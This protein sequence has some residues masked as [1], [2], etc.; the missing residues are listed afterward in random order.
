MST[1]QLSIKAPPALAI[2]PGDIIPDPGQAGPIVWSTMVNEYLLWNGT[3]WKRLLNPVGAYPGYHEIDH[4][5]NSFAQ[6]DG[7]VNLG[8][9]FTPAA[10]GVCYG[11]R[12]Y[13]HQSNTGVHR[14]GIWKN[15]AVKATGT[16]VN[17]TAYGWQYLYFDEPVE[18]D[19]GETYVVGYFCPIGYFAIEGSVFAS[20]QTKNGLRF[21]SGAGVFYYTDHLGMPATS[22][23]GNASY[24]VDPLVIM[25]GGEIAGPIVHSVGRIWTDN[26]INLWTLR[27]GGTFRATLTADVALSL[28][29]GTDGQRFTLELT[30]DETGG[31]AATLNSSN[32]KFGSDIPSYTA[33]PTAGKKDRISCIATGTATADVVAVAK[34]YP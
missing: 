9:Q 20:P 22:S 2:A 8:V 12:F 34:G 17:E 28:Q 14:G 24:G 1:K 7:D 3:F 13:K 32:F 4:T 25:N 23:P 16:F 29:Y 6:V 31:H 10:H 18:L 26:T 33:T 21:G 27:D 19:P 15:Y 5:P 30:Q 11:I